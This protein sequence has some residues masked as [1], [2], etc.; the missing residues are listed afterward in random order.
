[1]LDVVRIVTYLTIVLGDINSVELAQCETKPLHNNPGF[2][3][4][5]ATKRRQCGV[6]E[7]NVGTNPSK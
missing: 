4:A 7:G 2:T 1:M 3:H 6:G 5:P